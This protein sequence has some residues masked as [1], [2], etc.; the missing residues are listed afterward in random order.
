MIRWLWGAVVCCLALLV[1][2]AFLPLDLLTVRPAQDRGT[3]LAAARIEPGWMVS[4]FYL[5]PQKD[6]Q[7]EKRF[8]A[9]PGPVWIGLQTRTLMGRSSRSQTDPGWVRWEGDWLVIREEGRRVPALEVDQ[10]PSAG[11]RIDAGGQEL[12]LA[13]R[14]K[15]GKVIIGVERRRLWRW[16]WW[17]LT[18]RTFR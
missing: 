16:A 14:L 4:V 11:V 8:R 1:G 2:A 7:V 3:C 17:L 12:V 15:E 13:E 18:G 6:H 5:D 9:G 10:S